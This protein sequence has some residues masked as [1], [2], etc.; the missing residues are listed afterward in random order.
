MDPQSGEPIQWNPATNQLLMTLTP[1]NQ[2]NA[3]AALID[4]DNLQIIQ[5]INEPIIEAQWLN[6]G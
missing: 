4:A 2:I 6:T 5:V 3:R 1:T